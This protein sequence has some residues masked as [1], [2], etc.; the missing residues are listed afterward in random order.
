M[1]FKNYPLLVFFVISVLFN[2]FLLRAI[3]VH[4]FFY[5]KPLVMDLAMIFIISSLGFLFKS[6]KSRDRYFIF[7]SIFTSIVCVIHSIYYSYYDSF[8][9]ISLLATSTFVVDV[10]D[11]VVEKVMRIQDF[12]YLWQPIFMFYVLYHI[13]KKIKKLIL[14][15][16]SLDLLICL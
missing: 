1:I 7:F 13:K 16:E 10:G 9:S 12:I 2:S 14:C 4:N 8:A 5:I 6:N 15:Q 11:A 3:T